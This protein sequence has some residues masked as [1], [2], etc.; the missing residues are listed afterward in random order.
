MKK[1]NLKYLIYTLLSGW[2]MLFVACSERDITTLS[3]ATYPTTPEVYIDGFSSTLDFNAWGKTTNF[4]T[5]KNTS[6][7]HS[8]TSAIRIDV[9]YE[10]DPT[11]TW[12]GGVFFTKTPRDLSG[13]TALTFYAKASQ[14]ASIIIGFGGGY[15]EEKYKVTLNGAKISTDWQKFIIPIP[16]PSKLTKETAMLYYSAAPDSYGHGYSVWIDDVQFEKLG[17]IA[18]P[19]P[20]IGGGIESTDVVFTGQEYKIAGTVT[21]N[22][23]SGIDE[24]VEVASGYFTFSSDNPSVATVNEQGSLNIISS[25]T[26]KITAKMGDVDATG[27]SAITVIEHAPTPT[28]TA[29]NVSSLFCDAY[30]NA[31]IYDFWCGTTKI[32]KITAGVDNVFN[33]NTLDWTCPVFYSGALG[34]VNATN[35]SY[36]HVDFLTPMTVTASSKLEIKLGDLV[37]GA[38]NEQSVRTYTCSA[39]DKGKW[40]QLDIPISTKAKTKVGYLTFVGTNLTNIYVDNIYFYK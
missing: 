24:T 38:K 20:M 39:A 16:N 22:L 40:I 25:G 15:G 36:L 21:F 34:Y 30:T 32:T 7:V 26:A 4:Q 9:P 3:L 27:S 5:E 6:N 1:V 35:Y 33:F 10:D 11:G 2:M 8:G 29:D 18:N 13:Y 23:P 17:T 14:S 19:R 37:T 12:A 31:T 28:K